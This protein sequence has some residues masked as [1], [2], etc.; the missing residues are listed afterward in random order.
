[1]SNQFAWKIILLPWVGV[2]NL[3]HKKEVIFD[4]CA[5]IYNIQRS[6]QF[7]NQ[8]NI[9]DILSISFQNVSVH[10]YLHVLIY[11][12]YVHKYL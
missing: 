7:L 10:V 9:F 1:M 3:K 2:F 11:I 5:H 12:G 6:N 4:L 8:T